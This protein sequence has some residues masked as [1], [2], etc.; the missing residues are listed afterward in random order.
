MAGDDRADRLTEL[1][2]EL[3]RR[4]EDLALLA[5]ATVELAG[6]VDTHELGDSTCRIVARY[7]GADCVEVQ[8]SESTYRHVERFAAGGLPHDRPADGMLPLETAIGRVG[9]LR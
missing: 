2:A 9:E 6:S 8:T 7:L 5:D 4:Q 3:A 1:E